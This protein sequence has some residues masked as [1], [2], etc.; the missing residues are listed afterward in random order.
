[1]RVLVVL[2]TFREEATIGGVLTAVR[3]AAPGADVLVVDDAGGD[4]TAEVAE[5]TAAVVGR[6]EVLRRPG[7]GGLG[8]AYRTGFALGLER[9]YDVI[10]EMDADGSH[11]PADLPRLVAACEA[12]AGLAIGS[13]YVPGGEIPDWSLLRRLVSFA[14]NRYAAAALRLPVRDL[15][16]GL[17][18]YRAE[19]LRQIDPGGSRADGYAF[20]VE[21]AD[22]AAAVGA[23]IVEIPITFRDRL[24]GSSKMSPRIVVEALVLVTA[25]GWRAR[26]GRGRRVPQ[27]VGQP[28]SSGSSGRRTTR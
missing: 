6:V 21:L 15:T 19:V 10:V 26:V 4:A 12:G 22:R 13:R 5:A 7:K 3:A 16:A 24:G 25:W 9:G 27:E 2:P 1:M 8:A 20:Q 23:T 14:G 17:R 28:S 18:A 11:D